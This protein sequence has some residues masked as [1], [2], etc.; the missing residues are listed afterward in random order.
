MRRHL[1]SPVNL[2]REKWFTWCFKTHKVVWLWGWVCA[3]DLGSSLCIWKGGEVQFKEFG[4]R[5]GV[6]YPRN[7]TQEFPL[8]TCYCVCRAS[9]LRYCCYGWSCVPALTVRTVCLSKWLQVILKLEQ[10]NVCS[11]FGV[12]PKIML[13]FENKVNR[14]P[15]KILELSGNMT[16]T[17][18]LGYLLDS[19]DSS[20]CLLLALWVKALRKGETAIWCLLS[21][22]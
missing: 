4:K 1:W 8:L 3:S 5:G 13:H 15:M 10:L 18:G 16:W 19:M 17:L 21:G 20:W 14:L 11:Y 6:S 9:L 12:L 7:T 2:A 22:L